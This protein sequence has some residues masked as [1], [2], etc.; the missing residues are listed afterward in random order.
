MV[1]AVASLSLIVILCY[2]Q[3]NPFF[4]WSNKYTEASSRRT[5][6]Q[7]Q[8]GG[9]PGAVR[10]SG[11]RGSCRTLGEEAELAGGGEGPDRDTTFRRRGTARTRSPTSQGTPAASCGCCLFSP[12]CAM[13]A[14]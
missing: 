11:E 12:T 8:A 3:I 9:G 6:L 7:F 1:F 5:R 4:C 13:S 2:F 10:R 14:H